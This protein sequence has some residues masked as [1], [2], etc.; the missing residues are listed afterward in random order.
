MSDMKAWEEALTQVAHIK[1]VDQKT[2]GYGDLFKKA[3]EEVLRAM[4]L[5]DVDS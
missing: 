1:G 4:G 2:Y 5:L 3:V